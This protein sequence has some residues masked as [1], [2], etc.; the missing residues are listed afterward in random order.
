MEN[1]TPYTADKYD[2]YNWPSRARWTKRARAY[3]GLRG[4][5]AADASA[6]LGKL[7]EYSP[8]ARSRR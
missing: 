3:C 8:S 2:E 4:G 5:G 7:V 6:S 1:H